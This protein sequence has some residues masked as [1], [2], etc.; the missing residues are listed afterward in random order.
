M[1]WD[2]KKWR[3]TQ[4]DLQEAEQQQEQGDEKLTQMVT[5]MTDY[6][7]NMQTTLGTLPNYLTLLMKPND[8]AKSPEQNNIDRDTIIATMK[9]LDDNQKL[10]TQTYSYFNKYINQKYKFNPGSMESKPGERVKKV[11]KGE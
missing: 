11:N 1:T 9:S 4:Y 8:P 6:V 7:M 3:R 5:S 2:D 10:L